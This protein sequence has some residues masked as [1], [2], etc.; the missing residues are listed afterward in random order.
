MSE[1]HA[2]LQVPA[3]FPWVEQS[4]CRNTDIELFFPPHGENGTKAKEIC[5]TCPVLEPCREW[6]IANE[7]HGIWGGLS[8]KERRA[9]R[10]GTKVSRICGQCRETF[11]AKR[12]AGGITPLC[13]DKCREAA[14][15]ATW[16]AFNQRQR[17][18]RGIAS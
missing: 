12:T 8:M 10:K 6:G 11:M 3:R 14:R 18:R 16:R 1:Y 4:A 2:F 13:S 17:E 7:T 15:V 9:L 5:A